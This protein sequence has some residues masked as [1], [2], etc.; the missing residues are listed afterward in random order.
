[1]LPDYGYA[2]D[3]RLGKPYDWRLMRRLLPM[4]RPYRR[5]ILASILLVS[6]ITLLDLSLPYLTKTAIDRYIVPPAPAGARAGGPTE[7]AFGRPYRV[8]LRDPVVAAIA[9]RHPHLFRPEGESALI[10]LKDLEKLPADTIMQ[11]RKRDLEGVARVT[12]LFLCLILTN[13]AANFF[14]VV[15]MEYTGQMMMN[16]LRIRL[17][18]H[19]Q[20]LPT[21]YFNRHPVGR[22]VTR[23]T[24]DIQNMHELFTSVISFLFK[25]LF[26]LVGIAGVMALL[27]WKLALAAFSVFPAVA[28]ASVW[29]S[30]RARDIF[31]LL[32]VQVAEINI[33]FSETIGGIRILPLFRQEARN[34]RSFAKLNHEN[35]R[36][37]MRQIHVLAVFLPL[38]ELLGVVSIAI[39]IYY[40]G[41]GVI[42]QALTLGS[43][44][45]FISYMRMFFRPIRDIAE[46]YNIL[47]N[48]MAS[49][50]RIFLVLD[51]PGGG[52]GARTGPAAPSP[53]PLTRLSLED[54]SFSYLPGEPVLRRV[55]LEIRTGE[56][57]A[58][59]GPTGSG[60]STLIH[61]IGRLYDPTGG[62]IRLNGIDLA[63]IPA[64]RFRPMV[65]LVSQESFLFSGTIREN[66][67]YGLAPEAGDN[68][69]RVLAAA[70]CRGFID[71]LPEGVETVLGEGGASLSSGQ[72]QLLSIARALARDPQLIL[73]DEATSFIDSQTE[74]AVQEAM[75]R[76]LEGRTAVV[77]A[78]R[79][80][81]IRN[82]DRIAVL[83][84]GRLIEEGPHEALM[85]KRGFYFRLTSCLSE[86]CGL[87]PARALSPS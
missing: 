53:G 73:L 43:L 59:V 6:L 7:A 4:L 2:E 45:A 61:L 14:Q 86:D 71:R 18:A 47:Q 31:R 42:R 21:A 13:F 3:A 27:N 36:V 22:L 66:L 67:L 34:F 46:K 8:D 57:L 72:R 40:G 44:V 58:V 29:F 69:D 50:E 19:I 63:E 23:V 79:L 52:P 1:V 12:L 28:V 83:H 55:S 37:G 32:R 20:G 54:L 30:R 48:A 84:R 26:L 49:A 65:A 81:T 82:A 35:Y 24:N 38:V 62:R 51:N 17:Y 77:V 5:T 33:R 56:T 41:S 39:V 64:D 87:L 16:D 78:H 74:Q 80:S 11:L 68:L 75:T 9:D 70:N 85:E 25:D 60:K 15:T 76:L 10:A